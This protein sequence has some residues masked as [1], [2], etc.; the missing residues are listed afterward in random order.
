MRKTRWLVIFVVVGMLAWSGSAEASEVEAE[1]RWSGLGFG[2][3][4]K[5]GAGWQRSVPC[6]CVDRGLFTTEFAGRLRYR[7]VGLE[8]DLRFGSM[9]LG[10]SFP[11]EGWAVGGRVEVVRA[12]ESPWGAL[13]VRGGYRHWRVMSMREDS[14]GIFGGVSWEIPIVGPLGLEVDAVGGRTFRALEHWFL[15]GTLGVGVRY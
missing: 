10:G 2:V 4:V 6:G 15:M 11:A 3:A 14:P 8:A 1:N 12:R 7:R 5:S 13:H 9:L